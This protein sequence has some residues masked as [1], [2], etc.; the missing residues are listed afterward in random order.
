MRKKAAEPI[1][2]SPSVGYVFGIA[3]ECAMVMASPRKVRKADISVN[4]IVTT[5]VCMLASLVVLNGAVAQE[6]AIRVEIPFDFS[7]SATQLPAGTYTI[8]TQNGFTSITKD[9]TGESIFLRTIPFLDNLLD[10][11]KLTFSVYGDQHF[12]RKILCPRLHMSLELMPSK[13]EI[14]AQTRT[15]R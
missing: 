14:R 6:P 7:A 1:H 3:G 8:T 15:S 4:R 12:L 2:I 13:P 5:I 10:D 11:T 9:S